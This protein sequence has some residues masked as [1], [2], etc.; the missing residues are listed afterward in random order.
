[1]AKMELWS[2]ACV[3]FYVLSFVFHLAGALAAFSNGTIAIES[4]AATITPGES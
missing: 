4:S 3:Y 2:M 1:M